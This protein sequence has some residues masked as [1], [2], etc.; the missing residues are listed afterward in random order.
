MAGN[1]Q[2]Q[3][4]CLNAKIGSRVG[5]TDRRCQPSYRVVNMAAALISW[6]CALEEMSKLEW[7]GTLLPYVE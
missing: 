3:Q 4:S 2:R 5:E 6:A 7:G 1:V